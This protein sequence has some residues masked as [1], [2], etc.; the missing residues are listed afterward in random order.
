[1][2]G[3]DSLRDGRRTSKRTNEPVVEVLELRCEC[4]RPAC[5]ESLSVS[6]PTLAWARSRGLTLVAPGHEAPGEA[7]AERTASF[8][9]VRTSG[10]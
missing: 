7:V 10:D 6:F 5:R 8:L 1:M 9:L 4:G 2:D 3:T